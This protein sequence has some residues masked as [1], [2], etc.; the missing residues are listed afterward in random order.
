MDK[1]NAGA[2]RGFINPQRTDESDEDYVSPKDIYES[3]KER[4]DQ[5]TQTKTNTAA[6]KASKN[7][8]SGGKVKHKMSK[9]AY[10]TVQMVALSVVILKGICDDFKPWHG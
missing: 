9:E 8:K 2:G 7:M 1:K 3:E 4:S 6:E 5:E 10:R